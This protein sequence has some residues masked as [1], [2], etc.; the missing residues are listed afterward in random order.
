MVVDFCGY[1]RSR[2]KANLLLLAIFPV[3]TTL[4]IWT[5]DLHHFTYHELNLVDMQYFTTILPVNGPGYWL[6]T[7]YNYSLIVLAYGILIRSYRSATPERR[8]QVLMIIVGTIIPVLANVLDVLRL[9]P[10]MPL[11]LTVF[12]LI[13][14][15]LMGLWGL[16]YRHLFDLSPLARAKLIE[17]IHYGVI[18][19]DEEG[20][21]SD[22]NPAAGRV[23][24]SALRVSEGLIGKPAEK[25]LRGW[26]ALA[27]LLRVEASSSGQIALGD[28]DGARYFDANVHLIADPDAPERVGRLLM[29]HE[30]TERR[31]METALRER[32]ERFRMMIDVL[33]QPV[34]LTKL[35]D[36][37]VMYLNRSG[38]DLFELDEQTALGRKTPQFYANPADRDRIFAAL[39]RDGQ[40][41]D[42]EVELRRTGGSTFWAV[43][44]ASVSEFR[45]EQVL[46]VGLHDI[47]ERRQA[48]QQTLE[49]ALE[50][51]KIHI[52]ETFIRDASHDFRTPISLLMTSAYL[53]GKLAQ[54]TKSV[55]NQLDGRADSLTAEQREQALAEIDALMDRIIEKASTTED[56][57]KRL[58]KIVGSML[59]V[60]E[61]EH[62][63]KFEFTVSDINQFVRKV[64][65]NLQDQFARKRIRQQVE[66][67]PTPLLVKLADWELEQALRNILDNAMLFTPEGGL[68][69]VTISLDG[70]HAV[71]AVSDSGIGIPE[72]D[73]PQIFG[74]FYRVDEARST[75]TGGAGLGLGISK[76]IVEA[77][78]GSIEVESVLGEGS[79][80]RVF[81]PLATTEELAAQR[82]SDMIRSSTGVQ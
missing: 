47:T 34:V 23:L 50:R 76:R 39:E 28:G 25:V 29:L 4:L 14:S 1:W 73:L 27:G 5:N 22:F 38:A 33:P 43:I 41:Y 9:H 24:K 60:T 36:N 53:V 42:F 16:S 75:M 70:G 30:I 20:R 79:T 15:G 49:L 63:L 52:M 40:V 10:L 55:A 7:A 72:E 45:G 54:K 59:R 6:M 32:E 69:T 74:H 37:T 71:I 67:S 21:V 2:R 3:I 62:K 48:E 65:E 8:R 35:A 58:E 80:F 26:P 56:N 51:E 18:V 77:H 82:S 13:P 64:L 31:Q 78:G 61:L 44:S 46:L 57:A 17:I 66:N 81:L 11:R 12:A 68:I 19:I